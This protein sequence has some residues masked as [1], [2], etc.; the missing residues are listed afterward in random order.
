MTTNNLKLEIP[1]VWRDVSPDAI[2]LV[3]K[4]L[5]RL[6][7]KPQVQMSM[8]PLTYPLWEKL[9]D[10]QKAKVVK[11]F[12][13]QDTDTQIKIVNLAIENISTNAKKPKLFQI[14][15]KLKALRNPPPSPA[16]VAEVVKAHTNLKSGTGSS[17]KVAMENMKVEALTGLVTHSKSAHIR[18]AAEKELCKIAGIPY[19]I[20]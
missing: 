4:T 8:V 16:P 5:T 3:M 7:T 20:A 1:G 11:R 6:G 13:E 9:N 15:K 12:S 10:D 19:D 18:I 17:K 2:I 14:K